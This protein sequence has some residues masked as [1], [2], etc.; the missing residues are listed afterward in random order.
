MLKDFT[1]KSFCSNGGIDMT[2]M[3][4][5]MS[6]NKHS[7]LLLTCLLFLSSAIVLWVPCAQAQGS[8]AKSILKAMSDYVSSQKTIEIT[9]DSDIEIITPHME[10]IQ[11]TNSGEALLSRPDKLRAHRVGGYS[12]VVLFFDGKTASVFG[13]NINGYAQFDA[14]GTV[15]QLIEALRQ[16]NGIALPGADLLLSNSYNVL[17]AGVLEA[18]HIGRGVIDGR[19]CEHL[20]F[21][22]FDTDWQIWV[23]VGKSPIP[24]KMVITSKTLNSAPQYTL[25]V[26]GWKTGVVPARDAFA[27][28]PPAGAQKL[29]ADAL[30]DLDELPQSK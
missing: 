1:S 9:F 12:D 26:K 15:D 3:K 6:I 14:P 23:E 13:K 28:I 21:R 2:K 5:G 20:A 24:R 22:N 27:F 4:I 18:K 10:K 8:D 29:S 16:G 7:R 30:I 25:R 19:E 11:F 17:V